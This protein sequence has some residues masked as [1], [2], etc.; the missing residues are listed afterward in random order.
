MSEFL[1]YILLPSIIFLVCQNVYSQA[2]K[3][4]PNGYNRFYYGDGRLSSEG[5]MRD[6]KP[7]GYWK[8]YYVNGKLKSEGNRKNFML[9]SIWVFYDED[10]N[11]T[12]KIDYANDKRNGLYQVYKLSPD[13]DTTNY[14]IFKELYLNDLKQGVSYYYYDNGQL[15]YQIN[16]Q[17]NRKHGEGLEYDVNGMIITEYTY[18]NDITVNKISINRYD[19]NGQ[20]TGT[21]KTFHENGRLKSESYFKNGRINGYLKEYDD[22]G[23][24][25]AS[26]RYVDGE[27]YIEPEKLEQKLLVKK[28]YYENGKVKNTG[29]FLNDVPVG[30][31]TDYSASGEIIGTKRYSQT[32]KLLSDGLVDTKGYK[33]GNWTYYYLSGKVKSIGTYKN[34]RRQNEWTF[35]HE[36]G[37][38]EQKGDYDKRGLP[39]GTW[40]WYHDN[41]N[42]LREEEFEDGM[43][44]GES[45]E[46]DRHGTIV[47]KGNFMD[48]L[49]E[50]AWYFNVGDEIQE[51][52]F[53]AGLKDDIWRHYYPDK[54]LKF[55]GRYVD[56][57][58]QGVHKYYY[59]DGK[60][61]MDGE[62]SMGKR[63]NEWKFYDED[64]ILRTSITYQ[65]DIEQKIDGI[66]I[67]ENKKS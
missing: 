60:L 17:D 2:N 40:V 47:S 6:G 8:T 18:R 24:L 53:K 16:Y 64:G 22:K 11:I 42:V 1:K 33:Q 43:E 23:K 26:T 21:W 4:I 9:D 19:R 38:T 67:I 41:G 30:Q 13:S 5:P 7:D 28:E 31:H 37:Q 12:K 51:G 59:S 52:K 32:G 25:L 63:H 61:K 55:E 58:E 45:V 35:Y 44:N 65:F 39:T 46:Y 48:G 27:I 62:F 57:E 34:D 15:H 50:G 56:G 14:I 20:K 49:R 36:N 29:G 10:G 3:V 54:K 66:K